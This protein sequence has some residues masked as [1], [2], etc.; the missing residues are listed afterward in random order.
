MYRLH[1][2]NT[3]RLNVTGKI[4][5]D[6]SRRGSG[7]SQGFSTVTAAGAVRATVNTSSR[8]CIAFFFRI[9]ITTNQAEELAHYLPNK[10]LSYQRKIPYWRITRQTQMYKIVNSLMSN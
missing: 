6:I 7:E 2:F 1:S 8:N 10:N 3:W 5:I 9:I 4:Y